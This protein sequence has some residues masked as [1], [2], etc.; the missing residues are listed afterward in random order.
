M[1]TLNPKKRIT[2]QEAL[3]VPW[4]CVRFGIGSNFSEQ[5]FLSFIGPTTGCFDDASPGHGGLPAQVQCQA[6]VKGQ[7]HLPAWFIPS[8]HPVKSSKSFID[9]YFYRT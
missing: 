8:F 2:A 6:E 3:K 9:W 1:L 7:F 5:K 4:I